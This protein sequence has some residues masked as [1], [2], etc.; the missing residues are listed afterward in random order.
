MGQAAENQSGT[1]SLV[2]ACGRGTIPE[3]IIARHCDIQHVSFNFCC[4][5]ILIEV[6]LEMKLLNLITMELRMRL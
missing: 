6:V 4:D 5:N 2:D 3:R 1:Q